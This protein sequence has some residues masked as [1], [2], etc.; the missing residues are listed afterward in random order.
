MSQAVTSQ[1]TR[2]FSEM[3]KLGFTGLE[4]YTRTLND[5]G[6]KTLQKVTL[7]AYSGLVRRSPVDTARFRGGWHGSVHTPDLTINPEGQSDSGI[8]QGS[9]VTGREA[10]NIT[11]A[12][13]A[14]LGE[15]VYISNNLDYAVPLE[16]GHSPQ[17]PFGVL[18]IT[19][20]SIQAKL[21]R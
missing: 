13:K 6:N 4:K 18:H 17:A 7:A 20:R 14:K 12:L 2:Y 10:A 11:P 9:G 5:K 21:D 3:S 16:N 19:A 1:H 8:K 15:D